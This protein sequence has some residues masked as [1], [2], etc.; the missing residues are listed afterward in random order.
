MKKFKK[1]DQVIV[2]AGSNKN[3]TGKI[4]AVHGENKVTVEAK[5]TG[6]PVEIAFNYKFI[7]DFLAICPDEEVILDL[8]ENETPALFHFSS[9]P[10]LTHIIMPVRIQD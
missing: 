7:T 3:K 8:N 4:I 1:G 5:I 9:D 2:I 10:Q 6:D